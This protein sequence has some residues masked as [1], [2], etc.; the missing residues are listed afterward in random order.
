[1]RI[2]TSTVLP[3]FLIL[4]VCSCSTVKT[5]PTQKPKPDVDVADKTSR[6]AHAYISAGLH[7]KALQTYSEAF[8]SYPGNRVLRIGYISTG[9]HIRD[10]ADSSFQS[11]QFATAGHIYASLY[12]SA[13]VKDIGKAAGLDSDYLL[14]RIDRCSEV[15]NERGIAKYREGKL[16]EAVAIWKRII[17]FDP[18]NTEVRKA[19]NTASVQMKN[20][21]RIE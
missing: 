16:D 2:K 8:H 1:M 14:N 10:L 12:R 11:S 18:D 3:L 20:L 4:A 6:E 9:Q 13:V 17:G 21:Q 7:G 5:E 19:I 15:L